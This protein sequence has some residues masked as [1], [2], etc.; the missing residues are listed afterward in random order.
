MHWLYPT[1]TKFYDVLGAFREATTY[2]P[3]NSNIS[4]SDTV[5]I[6]LAA[7]HKQIAFICDV[8]EVGLEESDVI[9][10]VRPFFKGENHDEKP[11]K[12][13]MKLQVSS[14]IPLESN[15][16]PTYEYLKNSGLSGM[17]MGPRKLENNPTL[18]AY[19]EGKTP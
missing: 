19:I 18:L 5:F 17:L 13:F 6:K 9:E 7:P 3:L 1:N 8:L 10:F 14:A 2:W 11:Q 16:P 4:V 12:L 15:S